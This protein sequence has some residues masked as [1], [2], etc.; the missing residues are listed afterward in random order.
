M[1]SAYDQSQCQQV[2]QVCNNPQGML[3]QHNCFLEYDIPIFNKIPNTKKFQ[4]KPKENIF[5]HKIG[6]DI[7]S[8]NDSNQT[9]L[10]C[11]NWLKR[12]YGRDD[13]YQLKKQYEK[14]LQIQPE[15]NIDYQIEKDLKRTLLA[16]NK[17]N[18]IRNILLA[19]SVFDPSIGYIQ[20][21]NYIVSVLYSHAKQEWIGFWLFV[22]L[23]QQMGIRDV[24]QMSQ[25]SLNK[26]S[27]IL[28]F[29]IF[30][31]QYQLYLN[32][33]EKKVQT[34][35]YLQ[36]WILSLLLQQIPFEYSQM[37][38]D[39]LFNNGLSYFY[40]VAVSL[41]KMF[42]QAIIEGE[43]IE[44]LMILTQKQNAL[45]NWAFI[46]SIDWDIQ[47]QDIKAIDESFE[48]EKN[49]FQISRLQ[50]YQS[51]QLPHFIQFIKQ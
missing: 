11:I 4:T 25:N 15:L 7:V 14:L 33:R 1:R 28:D 12:K 13:F 27:K 30:R 31:Y 32:L 38:L 23:I 29:Y 3:N 43:Q 10:Y 49:I 34:Q 37:Y 16:E 24:F 45:L 22:L 8:I 36:Q 18:E 19:Y 6:K 48:I 47:K 40:T 35:L 9:P 5:E 50:P 2:L 39:G 21:M 44:I 41:I 26:Y 17:V 46:L 20:G 51:A 42:E